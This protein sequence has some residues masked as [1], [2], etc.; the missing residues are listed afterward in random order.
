MTE[1]SGYLR[2]LPPV[3]WQDDPAPPIN[4]LPG[5]S[6]RRPDAEFKIGWLKGHASDVDMPVIAQH[7]IRRAL[8]SYDIFHLGSKTRSDLGVHLDFAASIALDIFG[9]DHIFDID[10]FADDRCVVA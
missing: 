8:S 4:R 7:E 9:Q 1:V 5:L 10:R 3:L 6:F 2:N